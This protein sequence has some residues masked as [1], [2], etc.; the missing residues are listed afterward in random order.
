M[1]DTEISPCIFFFF[2][3]ND[4]E[5][6]FKVQKFFHQTKQ[7]G[8]YVYDPNNGKIFFRHL[9]GAFFPFCQSP[10]TL[11]PNRAELVLHT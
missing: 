8:L 10:P 5:N 7:K 3:K 1:Q 9:T 11:C 6:L 2:A 4:Y